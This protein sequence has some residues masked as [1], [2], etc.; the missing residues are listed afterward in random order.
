MHY[1]IGPTAAG[2]SRTPPPPPPHTHT[3][4]KNI[5]RCHLDPKYQKFHN[6]IK[7]IIFVE[8]QV[9]DLGLG[10][11]FVFPLSQEEQQQEQQQQQQQQ[12]P[13]KFLERNSTRG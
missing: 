2:M 1:S 5:D 8:L 6:G 11:D 10:V 9:L 12:P 3:G 13:P 7:A 4:L